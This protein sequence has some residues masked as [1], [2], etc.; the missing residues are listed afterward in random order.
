VTSFNG[1]IRHEIY[2]VLGRPS[3]R[4]ERGPVEVRCVQAL[5]KSYLSAND[6][7]SLT[8]CISRLG[9]IRG[10][11]RWVNIEI[12]ICGLSGILGE[13]FLAVANSLQ[14]CFKTE[15]YQLLTHQ[16]LASSN[17]IEQIILV[18][19]VGKAL[20]LCGK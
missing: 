5:G 20:I 3:S 1:R 15:S 8:H 7:V 13:L 16:T 19:T 17:A 9:D 4:A 10:L 18:P 11:L 14:I 2:L 6:I 12:C